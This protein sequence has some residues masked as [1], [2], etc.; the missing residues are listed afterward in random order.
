MTAQKS[1]ENDKSQTILGQVTPKS[2][3]FNMMLIL[4]QAIVLPDI[5]TIKN[6]VKNQTYNENKSKDT[7]RIYKR[8][9]CKNNCFS[10][11]YG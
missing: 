5:A 4:D 9:I 11:K 8:L 6:N 3:H 1:H 7:T 10:S 2:Y